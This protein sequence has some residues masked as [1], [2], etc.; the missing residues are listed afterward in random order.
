MC[1]GTPSQSAQVPYSVVSSTRHSPTSNTPAR[2]TAAAYPARHSPSR[3]DLAENPPDA[4][5]WSCQ[6]RPRS[7]RQGKPS[8]CAPRSLDPLRSGLQ[9]AKTRRTPQPGRRHLRPSNVGYPPPRYRTNFAV[10]GNTCRPSGS[11][12]RAVRGTTSVGPHPGQ[13]LPRVPQ[14]PLHGHK[15]HRSRSMFS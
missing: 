1:R 15:P 2:I 7:T 8:G 11:P 6:S 5:S 3:G 10:A 4:S 14:R 12:T 13:R 9:A